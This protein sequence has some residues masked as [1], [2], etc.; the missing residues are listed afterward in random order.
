MIPVARH[1]RLTLTLVAAAIAVSGCT[2]RDSGPR[3]QRVVA[4]SK[5]INEFLYDIGAQ[6][7]LVARDLT[8]INQAQITRLPSVG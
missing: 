6:D 8:S 1:S 2:A 5:Q 7:V 4:V 3:S